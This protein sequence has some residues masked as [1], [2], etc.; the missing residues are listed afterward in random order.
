[1][2][3]TLLMYAVFIL[4]SL[5]AVFFIGFEYMYYLYYMP[6]KDWV[7]D[8]LCPMKD[9]TGNF[10]WYGI[11]ALF[12]VIAFLVLEEEMAPIIKSIAKYEMPLTKTMKQSAYLGKCYWFCES[13]FLLLSC[14]LVQ[15]LVSDSALTRL[16]RYQMSSTT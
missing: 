8:S 6:A 14:I 15:G 7:A 5:G 1:M 3:L 11:F 16:I 9:V 2:G 10:L 13:V 4:I 12:F